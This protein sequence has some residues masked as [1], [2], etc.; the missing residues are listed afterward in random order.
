M[1][2]LDL[3]TPAVIGVL[4]LTV[5]YGFLRRYRRSDLPLP[6]GPSTSWFNA[7]K[8]PK[9]YQWRVY[10]QWRDTYGDIQSKSSNDTTCPD[11]AGGSQAT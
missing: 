11:H 7:V 4:A 5:L 2:H 3:P 10:A 6:P 1:A 9:S 8:L